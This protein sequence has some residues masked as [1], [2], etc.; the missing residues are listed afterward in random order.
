MEPEITPDELDSQSDTTLVDVRRP[1][2]WAEGHIAGATHIPLDE[3]QGRAAE[4]P[5]GPVVFYCKTGDR[6]EMAAAAFRSAGRDAASLT[7][8]VEGWQA[9]GRPLES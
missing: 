5:D 3:L 2:E 8:G 7:G 4:V 1:D 9:A 6:A